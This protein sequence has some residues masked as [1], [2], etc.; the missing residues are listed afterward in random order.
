[1]IALLRAKVEV[2]ARSDTDQTPLHLVAT[3]HVYD[4]PMEAARTL[5]DAGAD[6]TLR[7]HWGRTAVEVFRLPE[8]YFK[9]PEYERLLAEG[10]KGH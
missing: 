4:R 7:D 3:H 8:N 2:N 10:V 1:M 5:I 6:V 9:N